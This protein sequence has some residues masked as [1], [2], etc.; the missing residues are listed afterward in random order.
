MK[1]LSEL[2]KEIRAR[3]EVLA[4]RL[5][6]DTDIPYLLS[7]V[8]RMGKVIDAVIIWKGDQPCYRTGGGIPQAMPRSIERIVKH[9]REALR[10]LK[11]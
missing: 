3:H 8:E 5:S 7:L 11:Q 2:A 6:Y 4:N 1:P 10:E 9:H